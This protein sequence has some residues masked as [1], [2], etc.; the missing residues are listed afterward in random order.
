MYS[1]IVLQ[2][3][4]EPFLDGVQLAG[5]AE[6]VLPDLTE[7]WP[8]ILEAVTVDVYPA[9][10]EADANGDGKAP[11]R[12]GVEINDTEFKQVWALAILV[13]SDDERQGANL[14]RSFTIFPSFNGR[15]LSTGPVANFQLVAL[16]AVQ[17]LC[18]KGFYKP[19]M[20]SVDLC[21]E[22]LQVG[23]YFHSSVA[24][25]LKHCIS[26]FIVASFVWPTQHV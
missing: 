20:L 25:Y 10:D 24:P 26:G 13:I 16:R 12:N 6:V 4:Y 5:V 18:A 15:F 3:R 8:V 17:A 19:D 7:C 14:R 1:S 2:P 21:H 11:A 23:F 9:L 22:L